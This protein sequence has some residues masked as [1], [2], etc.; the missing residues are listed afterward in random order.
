M[1]GFFSPQLLLIKNPTE[2]RSDDKPDLTVHTRMNGKW[3]DKIGARKNL[4]TRVV[5]F[6]KGQS[7][8]DLHI[9]NIKK[10]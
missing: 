8:A 3:T 9:Y 10:I 5:L 7:R 4:T 2:S 6:I 1:S